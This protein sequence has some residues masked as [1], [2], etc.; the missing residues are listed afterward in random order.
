MEVPNR[1]ATLSYVLEQNSEL[2]EPQFSAQPTIMPPGPNN[3][4]W[5]VGISIGVWVTSVVLIVLVPGLFLAP[6]ALTM[7][8]LANTDELVKVLSTDPVAIAIQ[9]MA[10]IP[11]HILTLAM[12]W[13]VVTQGRQYSFTQMLGWRTGG[14]RWWHYAL[15]MAGFM[16]LAAAAARVLPPQENEMLR[17]LRSSRYVVFLVAFMAIFTAPL[18]EEVIYRGLLY[19]AMQRVLGVWPA[20]AVVT[21]LFALV[22]LPQYYPSW[23][24]MILLTLLSLVLTMIRVRT[25]NLL[26]CVIL[27]TVFNGVQSVLLIA[28][29]YLKLEGT[30]EDAIPALIAILK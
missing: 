8:D 6:Y 19:S 24:T 16:L 5:K 10:I 4:P 9:I 15:I 3:P 13:L 29:P 27:H 21:G 22:H 26:P 17:I 1:F 28:E 20:V 12:A 2:M 11:A 25:G 18:V 14:M 23:S 30:A 7:G